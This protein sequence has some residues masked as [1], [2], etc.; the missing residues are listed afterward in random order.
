METEL[1]FGSR[2]R[3]ATLEALASTP[4]PLTAY[5]LAKL[6]DAEPIQVTVVLKALE[7]GWVE[8]TADGW[9]L[10]SE[11]LREFLRRSSSAREERARAEKDELLA[12]L[13][14]RRRA[15]HGRR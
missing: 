11:A 7:P 14:M 5:R 15:N 4:K 3:A 2:V 1:L 10:A 8:H 12:Q 6:A 13:K 9:K